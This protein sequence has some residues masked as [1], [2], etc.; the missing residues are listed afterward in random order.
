MCNFACGMVSLLGGLVLVA[1]S[2][3]VAFGVVPGIIDSV[4]ESE[5]VLTND[6]EQFDRFEEVPFPLTFNV[7]LFNVSNADVVLNGGVP[8]VTEVGPYSYKLIQRREIEEMGEDSITYR[9]RDQFEFDAE[10]SYPLT[11]DDRVTIANV[12]FH[13]ILQMAERL[14]PGLMG[15]LNIILSGVFGEHSGPLMTVRVGDLLFEGVS[16]CKDPGI[17]GLIACSQIANIGANVRNLEVL[18]DGSLRFAVLK[19]KNDTKSEKYVVSRGLKDPRQMGII[20][21]YNNSAYLTN[22]VNWMNDSGDVTNSTCNMVNGTDSGVFPPFV[23]RSSPV[24]ALN[25][26]ICRSAELR[27]QYDSEYEGIPVARFSANEWF[28]DNHAG[29]FC[30][31]TTTGITK[32]DGCLKKGAMELYSCVGEY[33]IY[34]RLYVINNKIEID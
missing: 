34:C 30:L 16:L 10:A 21:S 12:A 17:V 27:Y 11:E 19:Y 5:V 1:V 2:S 6:T 14:F 24:F 26:D 32:E 8:V 4:I 22:W 15:I 7:R 33:I 31:N 18:D 25:T 3:Y 23:D 9:R 29:C 28:L 20:S 13:S